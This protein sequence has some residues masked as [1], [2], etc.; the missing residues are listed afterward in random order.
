MSDIRERTIPGGFTLDYN[1]KI[2]NA[3]HVFIWSVVYESFVRDGMITVK[4]GDNL[5]EAYFRDR[6][7]WP[8][9]YTEIFFVDEG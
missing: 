8:D 3:G 5:P 6:G 9:N 2:W 4:P 1:P 7:E